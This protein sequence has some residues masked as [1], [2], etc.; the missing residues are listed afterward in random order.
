METKEVYKD[1]EVPEA[2]AISLLKNGLKLMK[3]RGNT[4]TWADGRILRQ[5]EQ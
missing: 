4:Q 2:L 1:L 3:A 5:N